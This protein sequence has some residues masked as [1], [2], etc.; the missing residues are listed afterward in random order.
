MCMFFDNYFKKIS[1]SLSLIKPIELEGLTGIVV[2]A[3]S[4]NKKIILVGNGG[5]A[6]IASHLT[7][8]FINAAKIKALNFTDSGII[9][10]F[11]NDYGYEN[12]VAK[13]LECYADAGDVVVFI[14]SSGQSANIINGA[15]TAKEMGLSTITLSGF[16]KNNPLR[17]MGDLNLWVDSK[18][19]NI[20]EMTHHIWLLSVV[21]YI[22]E[23]N[24][25]KK[26]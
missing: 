21:D 6:A 24:K 5:S 15:K 19:Y 10:C 22:I 2:N 23:K 25:V 14:S 26:V 8:D 18:E 9:T 12:W 20:V 3:V 11:A 16:L 4:K 17:V 13:A 7:V 1:N